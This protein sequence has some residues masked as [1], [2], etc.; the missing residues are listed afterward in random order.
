VTADS[1][2]LSVVVVAQHEAGH[3][4]ALLPRLANLLGSLDA[5]HEIIVVDRDP[6]EATSQVAD[7]WRARVVRR[8]AAGY[9]KAL[10][11][12]LNAAQGAY[13]LTMDGDASHPLG[14]IETMWARRNE[15][16]I[17]MASPAS[18]GWRSRRQLTSRALNAIFR[19]MLSLNVRYT[20]SGFRLY[21]SEALA[22]LA[23]HN[24][25]LDI[26]REILVK[27]HCEGWDVLEIPFE[28]APSQY[29]RSH[30]RI[31]T[32]NRDY[33]RA[34][35]GLYRLRNSILCADYDARAHDSIV[36]PQRYWQRERYRHVTELIAGEGPTLDVGAGSSRIIGALPEGS[37]ALDILLRKLRYARRYHTRRVQGS[38]F[39][40]P[41]GRAGFPCVLCSQVIEHVPKST[42][43]LDELDRV[44]AP[45]GAL[46][47][48]TPDYGRW[49]WL[50]IEA[51]YDRV[52][53][54]AYADEHI[55]H[56]TRGEL[57]GL[58]EERGYT[59]EA[60]RMI[61]QGELILKMRKP[62]GSGDS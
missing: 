28:Y 36:P 5:A 34:L 30:G 49:Q 21:R 18:R 42:P 13:I 19:R 33:L 51:I 47:L 12:G 35:L 4:R 56:Y 38:G 31:A 11:A 8:P 29:G 44:L 60:E 50:V 46:V 39:A 3:L 40:L 53:P 52:L 45:G 26:L 23:L 37:V 54:S 32:P 43:I 58:F 17:V 48:G 27:A 57:L 20:A 10:V 15:A 1:I 61:L 22:Q 7:D 9:G 2:D 14:L 6:D 62:A 16:E 55:S 41:F 59:I 25:H 24:S